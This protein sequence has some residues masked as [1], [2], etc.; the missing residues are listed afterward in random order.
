MTIIREAFWLQSSK[1]N[2]S[3]GIRM[4]YLLLFLTDLNI[5]GLW[6]GV[7][8]GFPQNGSRPGSFT[9]CFFMHQSLN[10][11][12][13]LDADH[14]ISICAVRSRKNKTLTSVQP[15]GPPMACRETAFVFNCHYKVILCRNILSF[16][17]LTKF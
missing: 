11:D 17:Y 6:T 1:R 9:R 15:L 4:C 12:P 10:H 16:K 13:S 5:N 8:Y 2:I 7:T 14:T 3:E